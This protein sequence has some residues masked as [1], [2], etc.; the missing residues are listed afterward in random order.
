ME[1]IVAAAGA[2]LA[3]GFGLGY[4]SGALLSRRRRRALY[5]DIARAK[6]LA[7]GDDALTLPRFP[8][9]LW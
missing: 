2:L 1:I 9:S 3:V 5:R 4:G 6:R 8:R 7:M